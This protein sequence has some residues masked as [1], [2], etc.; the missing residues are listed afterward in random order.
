MAI[1]CAKE[2]N[3]GMQSNRKQTRIGKFP[4]NS[5]KPIESDL[6]EDPQV[7]SED[8]CAMKVVA[9][10]AQ[11][12]PLPGPARR[13]SGKAME[14]VEMQWPHSGD[15]QWIR[16]ETAGY[17]LVTTWLRTVKTRWT[18]RIP[19]GNLKLPARVFHFQNFF[20]CQGYRKKS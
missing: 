9:S 16:N 5:P 13:R 15:A 8:L 7:S 4:F 6:G 18:S 20:C 19:S 3:T 11:K 10:V 14:L 12:Q 17:A 2:N 1:G